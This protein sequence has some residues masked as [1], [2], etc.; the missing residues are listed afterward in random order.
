MGIVHTQHQYCYSFNHS[1]INLRN[2]KY[3]EGEQ[4]IEQ[5]SI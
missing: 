1:K 3:F 5:W 4:N 2:I